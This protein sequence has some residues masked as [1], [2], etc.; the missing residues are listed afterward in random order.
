MAVLKKTLGASVPPVVIEVSTLL[1]QCPEC[2]EKMRTGTLIEDDHVKDLVWK[3]VQ[4]A[5]SAEHDVVIIIDGFPR[6]AAQVRAV[7]T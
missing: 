6:S 7:L 2:R 1:G 4:A 3:A 5:S